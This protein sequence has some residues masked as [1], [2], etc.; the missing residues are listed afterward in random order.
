MSSFTVHFVACGLLCLPLMADAAPPSPPIKPGL[1]Q[2]KST[3]LDANGKEMP[4][5]ET[6]AM[7]RMPPEARAQMEAMMKARGMAV[8]DASG[9]IKI[10]MSKESVDAGNWQQQANDSGCTTNYAST[11]GSNWKWHTTCTAT[12]SESDGDATFISNGSY[13]M[14]VTSTVTMNGQ[15][16]TTTR[17]MDGTFISADC[18]DIKPVTPATL[19]A[20]GR[21]R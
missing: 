3:L 8:P 21:G 19:G 14:K 9:T 6:A 15:A 4:A 20:G 12:R 1:W 7:A 18:G 2:V 11:T 16:R 13:K 10:C 17:V 5:P